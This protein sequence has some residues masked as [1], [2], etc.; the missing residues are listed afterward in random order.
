[1]AGNTTKITDRFLQIKGLDSDWSV[2]GDLPGFAKSGINVK[3][4]IFVPSTANDI[5]IIKAGHATQTTTVAAIATTLTA[6]EILHVKVTADTDQRIVY[7]FGKRGTRMWPF[8][9]ISDCTLGTAGNARI[10]FEL[11]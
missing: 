10:E 4:I 1:M 6:P 2:P 8:I 11:A 9:D 7:E 5:L 3:R